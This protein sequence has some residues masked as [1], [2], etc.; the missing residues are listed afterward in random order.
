M[1]IMKCDVMKIDIESVKVFFHESSIKKLIGYWCDYI[2]Q[3]SLI[4]VEWKVVDYKDV[5]WNSKFLG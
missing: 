4:I 2:T 1:A 3:N 5:W